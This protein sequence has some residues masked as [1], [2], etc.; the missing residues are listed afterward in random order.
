MY[1]AYVYMYIIKPHDSRRTT[2]VTPGRNFFQLSVKLYNRDLHV[3]FV[4][5]VKRC[6][7]K[8]CILCI[9]LH[10]CKR[11]VSY[12][13]NNVNVINIILVIVHAFLALCFS[14]AKL[15]VVAWLFCH[16]C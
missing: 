10:I 3:H 9:P 4:C 5:R 13:L 12:S 11:H 14:H 7:C 6:M 8:S 2:S 15:V 16:A 1:I